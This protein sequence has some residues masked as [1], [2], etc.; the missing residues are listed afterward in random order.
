M[1]KRKVWPSKIIIKKLLF[2]DAKVGQDRVA[3]WSTCE[4]TIG[5]FVVLFCWL[6]LNASYC[7]IG[8]INYINYYLFWNYHLISVLLF[9]L[10]Q[11]SLFSPGMVHHHV[12]LNLSNHNKFSF[13]ECFKYSSQ[14]YFCCNVCCY[15]LSGWCELAGACCW[16][17][18]FHLSTSLHT[19]F[20]VDGLFWHHVDISLA[21]HILLL[22][23]SLLLLLLRYEFVFIKH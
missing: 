2:L 13:L 5:L 15:I 8:C 23:L 4:N 17:L 11:Q 18:S 12:W 10:M 6:S 22:L 9:W 1:N 14:L 3:F 19:S 20:I 16:S 21:N 7:L